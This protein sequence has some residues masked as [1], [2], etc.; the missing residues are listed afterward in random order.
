MLHNRT[1]QSHPLVYLD[2]AAT[3]FKPQCVIDAVVRY[4]T[5]QTTNVHRGDYEIS[6]QVSEAYE[7]TRE[8]VARFIHAEP[9]EIV[10]TAG[11]SASLN[12][13]AY[14]YGRKYLKPG[15]VILST[16]RSDRNTCNVPSS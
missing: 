3:T 6:Y 5:E 14:G 16:A 7:K 2:N 8:D 12:L 13:V 15:D 9:K 10:F 4:Y 1:M 11:A